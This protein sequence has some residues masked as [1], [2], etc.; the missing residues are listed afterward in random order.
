MRIV[1]GIVVPLIAFLGGLFLLWAHFFGGD[2]LNSLPPKVELTEVYG[3]VEWVN[4]ASKKGRDVRFKIKDQG[5]YVH[6]GSGGALAKEI[7]ESLSR[8]G[9]VVHVLADPSETQQPVLH[10]FSYTPVYQILANGA[11][12]RSYEEAVASEARASFIIPWFGVFLV[13]GSIYEY[14]KHRKRFWLKT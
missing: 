2:L 12:I 14:R 11:M 1:A 6:N 13:I 10:D 4:R 9:V 3:E 7:Y 5:T 8:D